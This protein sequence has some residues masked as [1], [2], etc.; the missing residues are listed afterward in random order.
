[1]AGRRVARAA[2][3][4]RGRRAGSATLTVGSRPPLTVR[5]GTL[6]TGAEMPNAA[7]R[8]AD[9]D[10]IE[11]GG[12]QHRRQLSG[13]VGPHVLP[14]VE[15]AA[16]GEQDPGAAGRGCAEVDQQEPAVRCEHPA[17]LTES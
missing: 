5:L 14:A 6:G 16:D 2:A 8:P 15:E 3:R 17:N 10:D 7:M 1:M 12:G 9:L 13:E 11:V 4:A